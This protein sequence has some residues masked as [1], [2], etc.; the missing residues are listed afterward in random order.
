LEPFRAG[1]EVASACGTR[2]ELIQGDALHLPYAAEFDVVGA[3]DVI[4][5]IED[6]ERVL[7][8]MASAVAPGGG[9]IITVPQHPFLW[10]PFDDYS[11][12]CRRYTRRELVRHLLVAGLNVMRVTSFV[13]L[14]LPAM[15]LSRV[16]LSRGQHGSTDPAEEF[17][18]SPLANKVAAAVMHAE[19]VL[20]R[21]GMSLPV[22]G[23]LLAVATRPRV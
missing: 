23:S 21:G 8:Q 16:K 9:V 15:L 2:A 17:R 11:H 18:I 10:S 4:E 12:H 7:Q 20:I 14:L 6:D 22:G 1:L 19:R 3:F 5:H 13:S